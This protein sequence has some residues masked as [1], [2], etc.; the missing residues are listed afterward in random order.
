MRQGG[1]VLVALVIAAGIFRFAGP[2]GISAPESAIPSSP[3]KQSVQPKGSQTQPLERALA[4]LD[5]E[6]R[7]KGMIQSFFGVKCESKSREE[8]DK[9]WNV[10]R[11][12][13]GKV[14]FLIAFFPDP[15]HTRL[16]LFL[17]RGIEAVQQ[18]AQA[19]GFDFDRAILPWNANE[20]TESNDFVSQ[21]LQAE[22]DVESERYPGLLIFR[23]GW[24][25]LATP[26]N[27]KNLEPATAGE[28]CNGQA[29]P[30]RKPLFVFV[31]GE[32]PTA[33]VDKEQFGKALEIM[34]EI[35]DGAYT[36]KSKPPLFVLGPT[37]SGSFYSLKEAFDLNS[38]LLWQRGTF[39]FSGIARSAAARAWFLGKDK[40]IGVRYVSFQENDSD[41]L[42]QFRKFASESLKVGDLEIAVLS[43]DETS[44]GRWN[45][46]LGLALQ[47]PRGISQFRSAYQREFG[48][49][50][51][52][53]EGVVP[54]RPVLRLD[55]EPRG[56]DD[57]VPTFARGQMPLSQEAVMMQI[58]S[59]LRQATER[60]KLVLIRA[61]DPLDQLFLA[62]YLRTHYPEGRIVVVEPDLLFAREQDGLLTGT[63]TV[64]SY[65]L[66]FKQ[67]LVLNQPR[68]RLRQRIFAS[69]S[70]AGTYN[71]VIALLEE[72][73]NCERLSSCGSELKA[74]ATE[75]PPGPYFG[76]GSPRFVSSTD[77]S[78]S[79]LKPGVWVSVLGK[80]TYW[81]L[82]G[83]PPD[84]R[85]TLEKIKD[86][87][88]K[89]L[90]TYTHASKAWTATYL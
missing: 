52:A 6:E 10:P 21:L 74:T 18:A 14:R 35:Q 24:G 3:P 29:S 30:Q 7:L 33:G 81:A 72:S 76:Y 1:L 86:E 37:S 23:E 60:P 65:P 82:Q 75:I 28:T 32:R 64:S 45:Q 80:D 59:V 63:T 85:S 51:Q 34:G 8:L 47:F 44:Y 31:V 25:E 56:E 73:R 22:I 16:G 67:E 49:S 54:G 27:E 84:E 70:G 12:M 41:L 62:R 66:V 40:P 15:K 46:Q 48:N 61:T 90:L 9:H 77:T 83:F 87:P 38:K 42:D 4:K 17:D 69:A 68:D 71:A 13:R 43:E 55:L 58:I 20:P 26:K 5:Y 11:N 78:D 88:A 2:T 39:L 57:S 89:V 19:E 50:G 79:Y 53:P 36:G